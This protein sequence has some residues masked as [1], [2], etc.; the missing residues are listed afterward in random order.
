M[1]IQWDENKLLTDA[2]TNASATSASQPIRGFSTGWVE[3]FVPH[4]GD[5]VGTIALLGGM[6]ALQTTH[7]QLALDDDYIY[8]NGIPL[9]TAFTGITW[10]SSAPGTISIAAAQVADAYIRIP[11]INWPEYISCVYTRSSGGSASQYIQVKWYGQ[12]GA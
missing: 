5:A 3:I 11:V 10:A 2:P 12:A 9:T 7:H 1:R 8:V 4:T 6:D